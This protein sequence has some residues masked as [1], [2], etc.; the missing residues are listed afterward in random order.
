MAD[1]RRLETRREGV[2]VAR[3]R[4]KHSALKCAENFRLGL[5]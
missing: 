4:E 2:R 5:T 1:A 3:A